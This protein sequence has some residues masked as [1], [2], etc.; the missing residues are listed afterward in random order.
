MK[1][2]D[3]HSVNTEVNIYLLEPRIK[4]E[5]NFDILDW[6]KG[7]SSRYKVLSKVARDLLAIPV[8]TV[9]SESA[10]NT[11]GRVI[12]PFRSM[13]APTTV[14]ALVWHKIGYVRKQLALI[15]KAT[16]RIL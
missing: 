7:N 2:E 13:L 11:S 9:A 12:D 1:E 8:S 3:A 6:W 16:W 10:F 14:E 5:E 15:F 4:R